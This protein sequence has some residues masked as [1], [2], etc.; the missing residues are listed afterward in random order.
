MNLCPCG[1]LGSK[2]KTCTDTDSQIR[3]YQQKLS[4]PLLDRVDLQVEV[5]EVDHHLLVNDMQQTTTSNDIKTQVLQAYQTQI[6]RQGK[7]N[8]QLS[9][10]EIDQFCI[11]GDNERQLLTSAIEN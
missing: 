10:N 2:H 7:I 4:G 6:N 1:Y 8:S 9:G 11:L 3:C 5:L